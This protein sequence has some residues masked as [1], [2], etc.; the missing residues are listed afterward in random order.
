GVQQSF[1]LLATDPTFAAQYLAHTAAGNTNPMLLNGQL[2]STS[3]MTSSMPSMSSMT[4][5]MGLPSTSQSPLVTTAAFRYSLPPNSELLASVQATSAALAAASH[6][7]ATTSTLPQQSS[8]G[9]A[10]PSSST[11]TPQPSLTSF[12]DSAVVGR[13]FST[14]RS[15]QQS[16]S[17][18][19]AGSPSRLAMKRKHS[20]VGDDGSSS[21]SDA[22][23][24][25]SAPPRP[26]PRPL[27]T[28][29]P[30]ITTR[31]TGTATLTDFSAYLMQYNISSDTEFA[32]KALESLHKKLKDRPAEMEAFIAAVDTGG[33][34][35]G[36]C[37]LVQRTLDGRLQVAGKKGFPHVI[38]GK[39]FRF[40][41]TNKNVLKALPDICKHG[42]DRKECE[43]WEKQQEQL[44]RPSSSQQV[45]QP[46]LEPPVNASTPYV[47]V[48]PWHYEEAAP[49]AYTPAVDPNINAIVIK[50]STSRDR[51]RD[52]QSVAHSY[53][54]PSMQPQQQ[55][56]ALPQL[57]PSAH[58]LQQQLSDVLRGLPMQTSPLRML[59]PQHQNAQMQR[60]LQPSQQ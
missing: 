9:D 3:T 27:P 50:P 34:E 30:R 43:A 39:L 4:S 38:Y 60:A 36:G 44:Q 5:S 56:A 11:F 48:N 16:T 18:G 21:S 23:S 40:D 35:P 42:F 6:L 55:P 57:S 14:D 1:N 28:N 25:S 52:F 17:Q 59:P 46:G 12:Q 20:Q 49:E 33:Q 10:Q 15:L 47:C 54:P 19:Q 51:P 2:P 53:L 26:P 8:I 22:G 45:L 24:G 31:P 29:Q 32:Q 58:G 13:K 7:P 41:D 37:V